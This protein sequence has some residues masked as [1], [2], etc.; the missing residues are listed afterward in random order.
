MSWTF[1]HKC[2]TLEGEWDNKKRSDALDQ[3][4]I[5]AVEDFF[6]RPANS[7]YLPDKKHASK[8]TGTQNNS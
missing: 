1:A 6:K 5:E 4:T 7:T 8:K 2:S 3:N